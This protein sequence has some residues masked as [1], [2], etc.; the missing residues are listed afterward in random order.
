MKQVAD[1]YTGSD[2]ANLLFKEESQAEHIGWL[3]KFC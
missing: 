3:N 1:G 2:I